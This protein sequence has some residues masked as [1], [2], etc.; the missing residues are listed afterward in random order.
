MRHLR[1]GCYLARHKWFVLVEAWR[2][3]VVWRGLTHDLSKLRPDE[4]V[5]YADQ[6]YGGPYPEQVYGDARNVARSKGDVQA[7]FD[8]AWLLH[9]RRIRNPLRGEDRRAE[10]LRRSTAINPR[11]RACLSIEHATIVA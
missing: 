9:Q 6:S 4:W 2:L 5:A 1:Y 3:G 10:L 7:A 11:L 8:R